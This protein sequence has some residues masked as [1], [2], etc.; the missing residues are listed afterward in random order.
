MSLVE[1]T[2]VVG[3]GENLYGVR[4]QNESYE[5]ANEHEYTKY[6]RLWDDPDYTRGYFWKTS[7]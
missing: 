7:I 2:F 5:N 6:I 4:F 1:R 3:E